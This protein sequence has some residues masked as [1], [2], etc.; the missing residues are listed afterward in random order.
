MKYE[1]EQKFQLADPAAIESRLQALGVVAREPVEQHDTYFAHPARDFSKTD[2]ALRLRRVG[3][4]RYITYKGPKIE[5]RPVGCAGH[6][7]EQPERL[8][9]LELLLEATI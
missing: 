3:S 2:E 5:Q 8:S 1:V 4:E 9:Y 7:L 6:G